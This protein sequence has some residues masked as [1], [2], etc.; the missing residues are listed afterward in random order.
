MNERK[1]ALVCCSNALKPEKR[2]MVASL[3]NRLGEYGIQTVLSRHMFSDI[4]WGHGTGEERAR[5]LMEFYEDD[6]V[7]EIYDISGG[8]LANELLPFLDFELIRRSGKLFFGYSDLTV[9]INAIYHK[10][11]REGVLYQVRNLLSDKTGCQR[12]RFDTDHLYGVPCTFLRGERMEGIV[13]GGNIRCFLKLAGTEYFPDLTG[14]ILL[15]EA[16]GGD[17]PQMRTYISQLEQLGGFEKAAGILLGT[18]TKLEENGAG[19]LLE[20]LVLEKSGDLCVAKTQSIG[21]G[22]DSA[23]ARIG[24]FCRISGGECYWVKPQK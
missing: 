24:G 18:F 11:G 22:T 4:P 23:A 15:L 9:L 17:I 13:V 3:V 19:T 8:D 7:T 1:A 10:T 5:Q 2:E 12:K 20:E 6:S 21:H 16:F 14:K